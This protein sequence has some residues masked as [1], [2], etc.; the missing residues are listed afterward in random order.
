MD[1]LVKLVSEK[2]G[3]P[4]DTAKTAVVT[5][6]NY[7]RDKLPAPVASQIDNLLTGGGGTSGLGDVAQS[8]GGMFGKKG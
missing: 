6:L 5:V 7:L 8:L 2:T 3:I 1:E 4:E